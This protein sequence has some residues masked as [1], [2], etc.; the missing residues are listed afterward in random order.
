MYTRLGIIKT[1]A[2]LEANGIV[3][4]DVVNCSVNGEDE[5]G[6]EQ[7]TASIIEGQKATAESLLVSSE[8]E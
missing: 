7:M 6:E 5:V 3:A 4:D 8:R 1:V 2:W